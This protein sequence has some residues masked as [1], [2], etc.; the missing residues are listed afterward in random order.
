MVVKY[1]AGAV[2]SPYCYGIG[3]IPATTWMKTIVP[4]ISTLVLNYDESQSEQQDGIQISKGQQN[5]REK[6]KIISVYG[7][8]D[9]I[10]K[11]FYSLYP[12][13]LV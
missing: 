9:C 13:T 2:N 5:E 3:N 8:H 1:E 6:H 12:K 10:I 4:T 7:L 11:R